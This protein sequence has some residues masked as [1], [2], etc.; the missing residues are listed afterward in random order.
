MIFIILAAG[1][2]SRLYPLTKNI[3][4]CLIK[5]RGKS[6]LDYQLENCKKMNI[7]KIFLVS[8]HKS[9]KINRKN[10]TKIKNE[11]YESTNMVYSL[12]KLK[13]LFNGSEDLIISYGD[14]I[15]KDKILKKLIDSRNQIS[16]VIDTKWYGYWKS[17]M[18]NPLEDAE[19][20]RF[21]K[22]LHITDIGKKVNNLREIQ[23]QYIGLTKISK[24]ISKK[25][26]K[27]WKDINKKNVKCKNNLYITDFLRILI[28]KKIKIKAILVNR[29]W[30]EFDKLKDLKFRL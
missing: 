16:T 7:K 21:T 25:V 30:L 5:F 11:K 19:S 2:G 4:K 29:G 24:K 18:Q 10:I 28:R 13:K 26:Y 27:T 23:G 3:P 9:N 1:K 6:I 15:Y 14:I 12:F 17:R 22:N 20:L 8:G